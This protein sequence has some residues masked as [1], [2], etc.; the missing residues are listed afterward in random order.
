[1][2]RTRILS[3]GLITFIQLIS[4]WFSSSLERLLMSNTGIKVSHGYWRGTQKAHDKI[5]N[6]GKELGKEPE[7]PFQ[8]LK[9]RYTFSSQ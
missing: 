7:Y 3:I 2:S 1:M 9:L 8:K 5:I 4:E 6:Y